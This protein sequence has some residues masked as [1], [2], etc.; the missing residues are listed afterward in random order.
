MLNEALRYYPRKCAKSTQPCRKDTAFTHNAGEGMQHCLIAFKL[1]AQTFSKGD[2]SS[3]QLVQ[4]HSNHQEG[5]L[6]KKGKVYA[7]RYR[8]DVLDENGKV[9]ERRQPSISFGRVKKE[10]AIEMR[11]AFLLKHG[12]GLKRPKAMMTLTQFWNL[13]FVPHVAEKKSHFTQ[14]LYTELFRNHIEPALGRTP[15]C[16]ITRDRVDALLLDN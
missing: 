11:D 14:K 16:D 7:Y 8:E 3:N 5:W 1:R 2:V 6:I 13:H 4:F 12:I 9:T 15:I 10:Q